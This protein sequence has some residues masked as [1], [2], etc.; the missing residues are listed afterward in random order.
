[1]TN[2]SS[3][4]KEE[5]QDDPKKFIDDAKENVKKAVKITTD[6]LK[7]H[8]VDIKNKS[9]KKVK[10]VINDV[11]DNVENIEEEFDK[12]DSL[13]T[14]KILSYISLFW[15]IG[16][17]VPEKSN[18]ELKFHVGQG[19][20]L[21]IFY[22]CICIVAKIINNLFISNIFR[23][24][25]TYLGIRTGVFTTSKLGL[26]LISIVNTIVIVLVVVYSIIGIINV[27]KRKKEHLPIIGKYAFYK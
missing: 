20:I 1:M 25:I 8:A 18:K 9:V 26:T 16:L 5:I 7:K 27:V 24:E 22:I 14:Y 3:V 10:E 2:K 6:D 11:R 4:K 12:K 15:I 21:T 17:F 13:R 23:S 19:M